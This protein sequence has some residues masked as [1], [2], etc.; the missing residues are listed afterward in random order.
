MWVCC[1]TDPSAGRCFSFRWLAM[2]S[3]CEAPTLLAG[4]WLAADSRQRDLSPIR[5][6]QETVEVHGH[7]SSDENEGTKS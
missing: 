7:L 5:H 3:F 1:W 6:D 4:N 2:A